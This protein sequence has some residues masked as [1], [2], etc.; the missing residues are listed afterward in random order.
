MCGEIEAREWLV[1]SHLQ[2]PI[3][4]N[5][6]SPLTPPFCQFYNSANSDSEHVEGCNF[7]FDAKWHFHKG[8]G[9]ITIQK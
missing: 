8:L 5:T 1:N 7:I 2:L 6:P 9:V 4:T 3:P